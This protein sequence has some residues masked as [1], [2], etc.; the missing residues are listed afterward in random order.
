MKVDVES[1]KGEGFPTVAARTWYPIQSAREYLMQEACVPPPT[2]FGMR[3]KTGKIYLP[4]IQK[5]ISF[6]LAGDPPLN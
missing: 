1:P 6:Q 2:N 5:W 4:V 3:P